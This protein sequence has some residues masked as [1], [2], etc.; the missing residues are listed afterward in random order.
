MSLQRSVAQ[1]NE[2]ALAEIERAAHWQDDKAG[3][4]TWLP[5][6]LATQGL[7]A[8]D[9]M[10]AALSSVPE[11]G[12]ELFYGTWLT[13]AARFWKFS[14]VISRTTREAEDA[15]FEDV[16]ESTIVSAHERGTGK[17]F[18]FLALQVLHAGKAG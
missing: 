17:S 18:G 6:L 16:T 15:E 7:S 13:G 8:S 11:Q 4:A 9:G 10:L 12:G 2:I 1:Q 5:G 3:V 14:V